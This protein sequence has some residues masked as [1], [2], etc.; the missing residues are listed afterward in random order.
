MAQESQ[1]SVSVFALLQA[2]MIIKR[3]HVGKLGSPLH[4]RMKVMLQSWPIVW[5]L[6]AGHD[7]KRYIL[8]PVYHAFSTSLLNFHQL[9]VNTL[10]V[11]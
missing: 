4:H 7:G 9:K 8:A 11:P 3:M 1:E 5:S 10:I 2:E 6:A